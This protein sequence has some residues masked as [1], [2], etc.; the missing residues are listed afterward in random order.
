MSRKWEDTEENINGNLKRLHQGVLKALRAQAKQR[1]SH[2]KQGKW[3]TLS[4]G[5]KSGNTV[6]CGDVEN[7]NVPSELN[8]LSQMLF[9]QNTKT[10]FWLLLTVYD[11]MQKEGDKLKNELLK[12]RSQYLLGLKIKLSYS[13]LPSI[14][15]DSK[16]KHSFW[17]GM[18]SSALS[19]KWGKK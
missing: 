4:R 2:G 7:R 19:G 13:Q 3:C 8:S 14:A 17:A 16:I 15:N 12:I 18:K 9:R 1:D 10:A 6:A 11:K 5:A